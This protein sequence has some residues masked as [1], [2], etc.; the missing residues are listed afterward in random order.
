MRSKEAFLWKD[1]KE[2]AFLKIKDLMAQDTMLTYPQ[3]DKPFIV[4]GVVT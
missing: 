1:E 4:G 2:Q 3:F